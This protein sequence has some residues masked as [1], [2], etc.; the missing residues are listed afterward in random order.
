MK[1]RLQDRKTETIDKIQQRLQTAR[2][3]LPA[4]REFDYIVVNDVLKETL[5]SI[6]SIRA[7]EKYKSYR[8]EATLQEILYQITST[9]KRA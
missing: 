5:L 8:Q 2:T 6:E 7:A 9:D 1:Q 4:A 3:E